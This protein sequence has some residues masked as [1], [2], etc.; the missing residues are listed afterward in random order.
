MSI[1]SLFWFA[2]TWPGLQEEA[3]PGFRESQVTREAL[4]SDL[5]IVPQAV[6]VGETLPSK[7]LSALVCALVKFWTRG[8]KELTD[9]NAQD[10][11]KSPLSL[12]RVIRTWSWDISQKQWNCQWIKIRP[13]LAQG[14]K[15]Q[16]ICP[17]IDPQIYSSRM[18]RPLQGPWKQARLA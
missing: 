12:Q 18:Q 5:L 9:G 17:K 8:P 6:C 1:T 14:N 15:P 3:K 2:S 16:K 11:P 13:R 7:G 10:S 4:C